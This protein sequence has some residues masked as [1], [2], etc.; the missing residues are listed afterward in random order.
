MRDAGAVNVRVHQ[1]NV[2]TQPTKRQSQRCRHGALADATF[3]A[4]DQ[5][6]AFGFQADLTQS[7]WRASVNWR[8]HLDRFSRCHGQGQIANRV[9]DLIGDGLAVGCDSDG[10]F[11]RV[12]I[13][14]DFT[15]LP[16]ALDRSSGFR[17]RVLAN[18]FAK[19]GD[20]GVGFDGSRHFKNQGRSRPRKWC[21]E[22][23]SSNSPMSSK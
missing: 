6:H 19:R 1:A 7:S 16:G 5:D 13:Q 22:L 20:Q 4:A 17:I 14:R 12:A 11:D 15:Q 2:G 3:A 8:L 23:A 18:S 10:H 21:H 9:R